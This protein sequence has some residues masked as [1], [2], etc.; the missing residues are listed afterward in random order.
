[1]PNRDSSPEVRHYNRGMAVQELYDLDFFRW[2]QRNAKLLKK[3]CFS[4]ADIEHIAEE[5]ADMGKSD[6]RE[7]ESFLMRLIMHLL[8]WQFQPAQRST[9]WVASIG[10]SRVQLRLI[11]KQSPSLKKF[12]MKSF[13][14]VYLYARSQASRETG[15]PFKAFPV[16]CPY[17]FDQ[18][19]NDDFLPED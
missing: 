1:M 6:R 11:F 13:V 18:L 2:T 3:G 19:M 12:A 5:I 17:T 10:D 7:V 8:K 16:K 4:Q 9:R 15:L 14:E